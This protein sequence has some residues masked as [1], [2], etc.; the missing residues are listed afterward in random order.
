LLLLL[1]EK[2]SLRKKNG[3]R[4]KRRKGKKPKDGIWGRAPSKLRQELGAVTRTRITYHTLL[5][6]AEVTLGEKARTKSS[7]SVEGPGGR[8]NKKASPSANRQGREVARR[9]GSNFFGGDTPE[10]NFGG[11]KSK[12]QKKGGGEND[13]VKGMIRSQTQDFRIV[14]RRIRND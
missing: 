11:E 14:R 2:R 5:L 13:G 8:E 12:G 7:R 4:E 3:H 10:S 1:E 6:S 9:W